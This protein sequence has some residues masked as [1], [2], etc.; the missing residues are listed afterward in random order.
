MIFSFSRVLT[1][2]IGV[3]LDLRSKK[4]P[5]GPRARLLLTGVLFR[6]G[7]KLCKVLLFK[8]LDGGFGTLGCLQRGFFKWFGGGFDSKNAFLRI[9]LDGIFYFFLF[10]FLGFFCVTALGLVFAVRALRIAS[11]ELGRENSCVGGQKPA[12]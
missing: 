1:T 10:R 12:W 9:G 6:S 11:C 8:W 7:V 2:T 4:A 3:G 5:P